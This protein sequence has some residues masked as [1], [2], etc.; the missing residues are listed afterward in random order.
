MKKKKL[1]KCIKKLQKKIKKFMN[2][3]EKVIGFVQYASYSEPQDS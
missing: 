1:K 2:E 3:K